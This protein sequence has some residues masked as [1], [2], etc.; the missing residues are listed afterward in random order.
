MRNNQ[1]VFKNTAIAK[2]EILTR[3]GGTLVASTK[4]N[5]ALEILVLKDTAIKKNNY[6]SATETLLVKKGDLVR[7]GTYLTSTRRSK[8]SGQVY[9]IEDDLIYI[10]LGRPYLISEGTVLDVGTKSL[11]EKLDLLATLVYDK[12]KTVDIVQGL[13]KVEEILEA[14]KIKNGCILAPHEGKAIFNDTRIDITKPTGEIITIEIEPQVKPSFSN[15]KFVNFLEPLTDGPI[16]PHDKLETLF[17]YYQIT[18]PVHTACKKS[19]KYLQLF[20]VNEVQRTYRSQGVQIADKHLEIIVKQMTSKVRVYYGGDTTLLPGEILDINQAEMITRSALSVNEE[21][22]LYKPMLL[23]LTKASLNSDSFISAA[24]F[25]ETTRV[26]TEA[27]IE[28][29]KDWLNG[30]KENVIIG[31]LIPAGTGFNCF[32]NLKKVGKDFIP[33]VHLK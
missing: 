16:S 13:P 21:P 14:R 4:A 15:G 9:K 33:S 6:S 5:N 18:N 27:A 19:L 31:R 22:P 30:L 7:V 10:R 20:L 23:G 32:E 29:K 25:Q 26:L 17:N 11:V 12:L 8:Y 28:G 24:S 3:F 1:Y 2:V